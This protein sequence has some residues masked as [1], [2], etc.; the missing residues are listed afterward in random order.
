MHRGVSLPVSKKEN[1]RSIPG[2]FS[3]DS[4]ST[5]MV[6]SGPYC[7]QH[8]FLYHLLVSQ[9]SHVLVQKWVGSRI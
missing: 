6:E 5:M 4:K 2:V 7:S 8:R 1:G 3:P 9:G